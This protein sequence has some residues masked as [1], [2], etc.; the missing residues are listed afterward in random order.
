[1][2]FASRHQLYVVEDCAQAHGA[3]YKG[4]KTGTFGN[5]GCFSFYPGKNLGALGD[6]GAVITNDKRIA[7][8]VR[9]LGNYGFRKKYDCQYLGHNSRLDEVQAGFLRVKLKYLDKYNAYRNRVAKR[10]LQEI[11]NP[12]LT[13][14]QTAA[15]RTHVWHIFAV[16]CEERDRLQSY[17]AD[18]GVMTVCHYPIP[19]Y[20]QEAYRFLESGKYPVTKRIASQELSLP[21]YYGITDEEIGYI[22]RLL[23]EF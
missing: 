18:R 20:E 10:Y 3:E 4:K 17:L 15:D 5:A 22:I 8:K 16:L 7:D 12:R 13:L 6:G 1:M 11:K 14:P 23:N 9:A 21:M 2:D 19:I